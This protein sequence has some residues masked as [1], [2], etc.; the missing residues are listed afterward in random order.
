MEREREERK[1]PSYQ[2][3]GLPTP[4]TPPC[5]LRGVHSRTFLVQRKRK[6]EKLQRSTLNPEAKNEKKFRANSSQ[7][8]A[9]KTKSL[10]NIGG[11]CF[12]SEV[13]IPTSPKLSGPTH[14][15]A[16]VYFPGPPS[17]K[18]PTYQPNS[19]S[20]SFSPQIFHP[21]SK[22]LQTNIQNLCRFAMK[23]PFPHPAR[24]S[25][26]TVHKRVSQQFLSQFVFFHF[27]HGLICR[28]IA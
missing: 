20:S 7:A 9:D 14:L 16:F 21:A 25:S 8:R 11:A 17:S 13:K 12:S 22:S 18:T 24:L 1:K 4:S 5:P 19:D 27:N 26:P 6:E 3:H 15:F 10:A 23:D 2:Y 28:G